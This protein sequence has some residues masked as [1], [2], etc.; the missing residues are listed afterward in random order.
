[1]VA[2]LVYQIRRRRLLGNTFKVKLKVPSA[3]EQFL[4]SLRR[5]VDKLII[6]R[7]AAELV[8]VRKEA[9]SSSGAGI[10]RYKPSFLGKGS[11]NHFVIIRKHIHRD[12][13]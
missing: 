10:V 9:G 6:H 11:D 3:S 1:V 8:S 13:I 4:R 7:D 12:G 2:S 5:V